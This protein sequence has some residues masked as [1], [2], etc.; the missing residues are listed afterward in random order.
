M[1]KT[2]VSLDT[3]QNWLEKRKVVSNTFPSYLLGKCISL[4]ALNIDSSAECWVSRWNKN[5]NM[6]ECK[7]RNI[8]VIHLFITSI[9]I[10]FFILLRCICDIDVWLL[11]IL[12]ISIMLWVTCRDILIVFCIAEGKK[13]DEEQIKSLVCLT[14]GKECVLHTIMKHERGNKIQG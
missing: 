13:R 8:I 2:F 12:N 14:R 4:L 10:S 9:Y 5:E 7:Y 11:K 6:F 3:N 1:Q